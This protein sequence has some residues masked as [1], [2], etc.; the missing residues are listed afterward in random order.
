MVLQP[1]AILTAIRRQLRKYVS[2][3]LVH[4]RRFNRGRDRQIHHARAHDDFWTIALGII[5]SL[6]GGAITHLF[7][8]LGNER[9]HPA[10]IIFSTLGA[11]LILF[12]C[13]KL[14]IHLSG[15]G[16]VPL[17]EVSPCNGRV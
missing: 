15:V 3:H 10:G 7:S 1:L 5:G 17:F 8:H 16:Y 4:H 11:I 12:I 14:K 9:F 13:Y 6:L 2:L